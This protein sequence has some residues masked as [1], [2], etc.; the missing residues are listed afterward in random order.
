LRRA[1]LLILLVEKFACPILNRLR[2]LNRL[3]L[4]R[5]RNLNRPILNRLRNPNRLILNRL[6]NLNRLRDPSKR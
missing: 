3:I 5:L 4:N 2:N 1:A 6:R